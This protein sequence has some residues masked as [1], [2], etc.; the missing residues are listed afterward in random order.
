MSDSEDYLLT[1][2]KQRIFTGKL[3][4]SQILT[5]EN[6]LTPTSRRIA[7]LRKADI[8]KFKCKNIPHLEN[9]FFNYNL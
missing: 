2:P 7:S 1:P 5:T 9:V 4:K 6:E 3:P 8:A